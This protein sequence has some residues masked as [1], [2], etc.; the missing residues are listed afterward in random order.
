M[1][2]GKDE[3][4]YSM[5]LSPR[6]M[7]PSHI[8]SGS[9]SLFLLENILSKSSY[10]HET[11]YQFQKQHRSSQPNAS[12]LTANPEMISEEIESPQNSNERTLPDRY[13][14]EDEPYRNDRAFQTAKFT[15]LP[16]EEN[17]PGST[18]NQ[19]PISNTTMG[20]SKPEN[21]V[22]KKSNS[23]TN[24]HQ[25]PK[26]KP[27]TKKKLTGNTNPNGKINFLKKEMR[28]ASDGTGNKYGDKVTNFKPREDMFKKMCEKVKK[29]KPHN[30]RYENIGERNPGSN[31]VMKEGEKRRMNKSTQE[32]P[33][34]DNMLIINLKEL[35][36]APKSSTHSKKNTP[37]KKIY[38][39][40]YKLPPSTASNTNTNTITNTNTNTNMNTNM[41]TNTNTNTNT[42]SNSNLNT[43]NPY[44]H[45][46]T[47]KYHTLPANQ[48]NQPNN[49][50]NN[51]PNTHSPIIHQQF[52]KAF[53]QDFHEFDE[54]QKF[55]TLENRIKEDYGRKSDPQRKEQEHAFK[56]KDCNQNNES[57]KIWLGRKMRR[58]EMN[59]DSYELNK[60]IPN[61]NYD[62]DDETGNSQASVPSNYPPRSKIVKPMN[63]DNMDKNQKEGFN[64]VKMP[65]SYANLKDKNS[66]SPRKLGSNHGHYA[67]HA[68]KGFSN[69]GNFSS[70]RN[71]GQNS[72]ENKRI[73]SP[74]QEDSS[75]T[76]SSPVYRSRSKIEERERRLFEKR[77]NLNTE[78]RKFEKTKGFSEES[79][80][81]NYKTSNFGGGIEDG[82]TSLKKKSFKKTG[83]QRRKVDIINIKIQNYN[84]KIQKI[85]NSKAD[86][87]LREK[88]FV[89]NT[90]AGKEKTE[91]GG[92]SSVGGVIK[93]REKDVE[94]EESVNNRNIESGIVNNSDFLK[95][96]KN[97]P[98]KQSPSITAVLN[99][100]NKYNTHERYPPYTNTHAAAG[101]AGAGLDGNENNKRCFTNKKDPQSPVFRKEGKNASMESHFNSPP[102]PT[103][104]HSYTPNAKQQ[105][106]HY[107]FQQAIHY[108]Y[109]KDFLNAI[110]Y[111]TK[112]KLCF[113][114]NHCFNL[115][116]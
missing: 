17:K 55:E 113:Y 116:S 115:E 37:L 26:A 75:E 19:T 82:S 33:M 77:V 27:I 61:L 108:Y 30:A 23:N 76:I 16:I 107:Y 57:G 9:S 85:K 6:R 68:G 90:T 89:K 104:H 112:V 80:L 114:C 66:L 42:N 67:V 8:H 73:R 65:D 54:I 83:S 51:G 31:V 101:D 109:A 103:H 45:F 106:H 34:R 84:E 11:R 87:I 14:S 40:H 18:K 22:Q 91:E 81:R 79:E 20:K 62:F 13:N 105:A 53:L 102:P 64:R 41:N 10:S 78:N 59:V 38:Y 5:I 94:N 100:A 71:I 35:E 25:I 96:N 50:I 24:L 98:R 110:F 88:G 43:A 28:S 32:E 97:S 49:S 92:R 74:I 1:A 69:T 60:L 48:V 99:K 93:G 70:K 3:E 58:D 12:N 72:K 36:N 56:T 52:N 44:N 39:T 95:K 4:R 111:F 63:S 29:G 7:G 86:I 2:L 15:T 47:N 21:P 46:L